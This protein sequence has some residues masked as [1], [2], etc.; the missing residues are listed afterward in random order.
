V[1][2][3]GKPRRFIKLVHLKY[4]RPM[5]NHKRAI[6]LVSAL[7]LFL[8]AGSLFALDAHLMEVRLRG[9]ERAAPPQY[10]D[11]QVLLTY[12]TDKPVRLVGAR[13]AHEDYR[14]FHIYFRN[15]HD[16]FLLLLD[17]PKE[18]EEL[19][20]R[21]VVDGLW[22]NDPYNPHSEADDF[23][24]VFSLFDLRDRP[25]PTVVSPEIHREGSVT[26][27]FRTLPDRAVSVAGDFNNWDPF[28]HRMQ[29]TEPGEYRLTVR[30]PPGQHFYYYIVN[31]QRVLDPINRDTARDFEGFRVST[32]FLPPPKPR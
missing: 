22:I 24:R 6:C 5:N 26:F 29:E 14:V 27:L 9:I 12:Q 32:F 7:L 15:E 8:T 3:K 1:A 18:V 30:M 17:V 4:S 11:R 16:V 20:Y 25:A 2:N 10:L 21:L 19:R 23:G 13:F 31:G 28:W